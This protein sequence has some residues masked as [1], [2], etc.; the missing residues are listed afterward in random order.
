[1]R[2]VVLNGERD[3]SVEEV[4]DAGVPGPD[5]LLLRVDRTAICGSDLHLYHGPMTV[6]GC[7][8]ATSSSAPSRT[9]APASARWPRATACSSRASSAAASARPAAPARWSSAAT[10]A[11]RCSAP[12]S[13]W[14]VAR[15]R[16]WPS[17]PPTPRSSRS[18]RASPPSRRCC[19][20]T[21]CP[22]GYLG[23]QRADITPGDVVVVIG[24]GPVGVF[25][26][27]APSSTARRGS[28]PS[29][30][31]PTAWRGPPS[32]APSRSTPPTATRWPRSTRPP[33]AGAP[34]P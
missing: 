22:T 8:S 5:G 26:L 18:P 11:R 17:P 6:P 20:P 34:T 14:P 2:A 7:T 3:V 13:S 1:M 4:P 19:S 32:S 30:W 25:A 28:S 15:P 29:T 27:S 21:S 23:A 33:A 16:P 9:S 10:P 12:R 24:L 31:C